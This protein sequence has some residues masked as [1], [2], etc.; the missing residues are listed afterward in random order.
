LKLIRSFVP[1]ILLEKKSKGGKWSYK[2][3][4]YKKEVFVLSD[5]PIIFR[6]PPIT[7]DD[8]AD[9][10]VFPLSKSRLFIG[11]HSINYNIG[12]KELKTINLLSIFQGEKY[13]ASSNRTFL[14]QIVTGFKHWQNIHEHVPNIKKDFFHA[15]NN[16]TPDNK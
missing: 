11:L 4:D 2:I 3:I 13:V 14:Q 8:F 12:I 15:V 1:N 10:F 9:S 6:K 5:N 7:K 16:K